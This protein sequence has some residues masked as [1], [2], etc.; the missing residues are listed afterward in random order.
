MACA[1][2][3]WRLRSP[4]RGCGLCC[5]LLLAIDGGRCASIQI[6]EARL[7]GISELRCVNFRVADEVLW[8]RKVDHSLQGAVQQLPPSGSIWLRVGCRSAV[9]VVQPLFYKIHENS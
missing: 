3:V 1:K 4:T 2:R 8:R 6:N 9:Q 7:E 5:L